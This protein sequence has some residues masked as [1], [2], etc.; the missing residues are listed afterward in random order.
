MTRGEPAR[1][2]RPAVRAAAVCLVLVLLSGA[3]WLAGPWAR[4]LTLLALGV[5]QG[6]GRSDTMVLVRIDPRAGRL[7]VVSLPRD[8]K[9]RIPGYDGPEKLNH[10]HA[11]GGPELAVA[12][13]E[14]WLGIDVDH[15]VRLDFTAL[16]AVVDSLG[17]VEL[18][19]EHAMYYHDPYQDLV[20]D[21]QA[22]RQVL[23]GDRALQ[24]VRYRGDAGDLS[25][26]G[27]QQRFLG[28]LAARLRERG[29][30]AALPALVRDA[31][32]YV[33]TDL[34]AGSAPALFWAAVRS[35]RA[36]FRTV[37]GQGA[38]EDGVW[39]FLPDSA[40]WEVWGEQ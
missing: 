37:P 15:W 19:V 2:R 14:N 28:A 12:T 36:E 22:G 38:Y 1:R 8:T 20:I 18:V 29:V 3:L 30:L 32:P 31:W 23:D 33:A 7:L 4:G 27:R 40:A 21:L 34:T 6:G 10:A 16:I 11:Y 25:R 26:I 24:Y 39:Y 17:G 35:G 9:V 5:D 13:V